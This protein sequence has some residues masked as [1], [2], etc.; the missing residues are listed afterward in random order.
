MPAAAD[1]RRLVAEAE[2]LGDVALLVRAVIAVLDAADQAGDPAV[3]QR[4]GMSPDA[5]AD[6]DAGVEYA[7]D[8]AAATLRA[9]AAVQGSRD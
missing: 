2:R 5:L 7:A 9:S 8:L 3:A 4:L 1:A 6:F